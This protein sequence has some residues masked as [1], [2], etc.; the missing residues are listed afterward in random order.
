MVEVNWSKRA[1][2]QFER[3]VKY[4]KEEQG[5]SYASIVNNRILHEVGRLKST[6]KL[7]YIEP[8]LRH[9]KSE[10]MTLVV[11]SYKVIY[12]RDKKG[13]LIS[14]VFHTSRDPSKIKGV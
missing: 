6:P 1:L 8:L 3:A 5:I 9:K 2:G 7:G 11:W 14:R 10:Y 12:K 13:V 4:I